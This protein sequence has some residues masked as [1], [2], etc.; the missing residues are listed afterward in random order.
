MSGGGNFRHIQPAHLTLTLDLTLQ[1]DTIMTT[2]LIV[3]DEA[4]MRWVLHV[5]SNRPATRLWPPAAGRRRSTWPHGT[6]SIWRSS[7]W[8][9]LAWM[10]GRAAELHL[11]QPDLRVI[12]LTAYATVPTAVR[13]CAWARW[14]TCASRSTWRGPLQE[15]QR[16]P[17]AGRAVERDALSAGCAGR[18]LGDG[19]G[20]PALRA[21]SARARP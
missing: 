4:N 18:Q 6:G 11:H 5:R 14:T 1:P 12:L 19:P 13:R 21:S 2:V 9:C 8:R 17:T 3:N 15:R 20:C 7:I 16:L 10:A